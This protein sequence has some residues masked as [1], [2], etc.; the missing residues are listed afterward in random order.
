MYRPFYIEF[1]ELLLFRWNKNLKRSFVDETWPGL[2][3]FVKTV[4]ALT[5]NILENGRFD[6]FAQ[7][8]ERF[9]LLVF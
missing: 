7:A 5:V 4:P 6:L 3:F 8:P 1:W 9:T 2:R